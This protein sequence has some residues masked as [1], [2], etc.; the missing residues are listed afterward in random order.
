M[1]PRPRPLLHP[2]PRR[3]EDEGATT[4]TSQRRRRRRD[5][6]VPTH[7]ARPSTRDD[8]GASPSRRPLLFAPSRPPRRLA[9]PVIRATRPGTSPSRPSRAVTHP[10]RCRNSALALSSPRAA[11]PPRHPLTR[12]SQNLALLSLSRRR[13]PI[14]PSHERIRS[15]ATSL[16]PL[17]LLRAISP[18]L[19]HM[20][21]RLVPRLHVPLTPSLAHPLSPSR[22]P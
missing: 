19:S 4:T 15:R 12:R 21:P 7:L 2:H 10:P 8:D 16:S 11:S 13:S 6:V 22:P 1:R 5:V 3:N 18:T 20:P 9:H 17:P 14:P